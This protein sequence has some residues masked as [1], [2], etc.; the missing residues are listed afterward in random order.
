MGDWIPLEKRKAIGLKGYFTRTLLLFFIGIIGIFAAAFILLLLCMEA[1]IVAPA[2][3]GETEAR[4]EIARQRELDA[5]SGDLTPS[6]YDYIYFD[7]NGA[8]KASSLEGDA[9]TKEASLYEADNVTYGTGV[10]VYYEDGSRCLFTW[11]YVASYT[12]RT[13]R[14]ILPGAEPLTLLIAGAASI[15]FF[16]LFVRRMGRKLGTKLSLVESASEQIARQD[17]DTLIPSSAGIREFNRALES[18]DDMRGNLKDALIRQWKSEQQ[19]KQEIAALA[20]DMKTPLTVI[21]GNAELLLED[22]LTEEQARLVNSIHGAGMRARQYVHALQQVSN[23]DI[24]SEEHKKMSIPSLLDELDAA[25]SPLARDQSVT[26]EYVYGEDLRDITVSP[27]LLVRA[28]VNIGENAIRFTSAGGR[29]TITVCQNPRETLFRIQDQGP[30]FSKSALQ[31]ATEMF[32]Q[33]EKS[34]TGGNNYGIGLSIADKVAQKHA[35]QLILENTARGGCV[36]LIIATQDEQ[37]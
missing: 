19:R 13:L 2:N 21:N 5:F 17:L 32:W 29:V 25:L 4:T 15:L 1:G 31:H 16:L 36:K 7:G 12:N 11:R 6:F 8:I 14:K 23:L 24:D 30:G 37:E 26:M 33:Q 27:M 34:W 35:G 28:L 22:P 9:L 3:A 18:M 20:H 10:Y